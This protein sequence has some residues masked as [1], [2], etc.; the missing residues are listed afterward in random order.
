VNDISTATQPLS[1]QRN[2]RLIEADVES[3]L[4]QSKIPLA[5]PIILSPDQAV[6]QPFNEDF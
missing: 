4:A 6:V 2:Y 1:T 5:E 3:H